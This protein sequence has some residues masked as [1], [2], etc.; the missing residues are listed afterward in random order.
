MMHRD[1]SQFLGAVLVL[2]GVGVWAVYAVGRYWIGL[3]ITDRE[4]LPYHF[5][6]VI[7]GLLL[8]QHRFLRGLVE[9]CR[10]RGNNQAQK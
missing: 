4:F 2:M 10:R 9:K 1:W 6:G 3:E 7:P 5:A 8:W